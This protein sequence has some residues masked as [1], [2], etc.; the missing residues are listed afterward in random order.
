[1]FKKI[2]K[3]FSWENIKTL[4]KRIFRRENF[5][6]KKIGKFILYI[7]GIIIVFTAVLFIWY[8][9]DLPNPGKIKA[10]QPAQSTKIYDRNG[11]LLYDIHGEQRRTIIDS[12][13]IP[14]TLKQ[15][16][17]A[18]EDKVFYKHH[19]VDFTS[20]LRA[21][22]YDIINRGKSQGGSTITQQ[23]VKNALLTNEKTF[24][25][26]LKE[27]ILSIEI[28]FMYS[29]DQILTMYLNEI[30]YG[31]NAYGVEE[32]AK[33]YFGKSAKDL[34]LSESATLAALPQAPTYYSPY[35]NHPDKL[36]ARKN[37]ILDYMA[38]QNYITEDQAKAAKEEKVTYV[39]YKEN[40]TAP[41]FVMYVKEKLV[42]LYGE[43][44]V[45]E[46]GLK[47]TTTLDLDKQKIAEEAVNWGYERNASYNSPNA[48]LVSMDPKTGQIIAMVGSHDFY[49]KE[50]D[51]QVNVADTDQQPG[52]SF[53]PLVYATAFKEKYNPGYVLWDVTTDFGNYTPHNYN[54]NN[55]GP[56][57]IRTA[58]SNS[59]NIPAVKILSLVGIDKALETAHSMGITGLNDPDKYGLSLVLG[60]GEVKLVDLTTAY[61]VF[62]NKG[63][64]HE[65][66]PFLKIEDSG[67]KT[68]YEY[69]DTKGKKDV[70]DPQV[71]YEIS[72]ILSDNQAR[73]MT[74]GGLQAYLS[75]D[76]R[77][78]AVKTGTTEENRDA[79]TMGYTPSVVTGVWV[80]HND[81]TPMGKGADGSI[82]AAPIWHR[83]MEN[84]LANTNIEQF[85]QP[86][87]IKKVT[88]DKLSNKKPT[89]NSPETITDIFASWQIPT[90]FDDIHVKAKVC[91]ICNGEK[92]ANDQC[93]SDQTE[94]RT[95]TNLHSERPDNPKWE[96]PVLAW[97]RNNGM[98]VSSPPT[99]SCDISGQMPTISISSPSS[100]QTVS[101]NFTFSADAKSVFGVQKVE[102]FVDGVSIGEDNSSPYQ[103]SYNANYLSNGN[104]EL[105]ATVTDNKGLKVK[106]SITV[107]AAKDTTP[108]AAVTSVSLT[109]Q[110]QSVSFSWK[111]P[112]DS[113]FTK[114]RIYVST[115]S[116]VLGTKHPTEISGTAGGT[117]T[118]TISGLTTGTKY[119][120]SIR[121]VDSSD[122]ENQSSTQ[123][124]A[125]PL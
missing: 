65:T 95:F 99:E 68:L 40:I 56:V 94:E 18:I 106:N 120:F 108:P 102:F 46:G 53:K 123:Y 61:G 118:Y 14:D 104:H 112:S 80:G 116:G 28:E 19:G 85:E 15:A 86:E 96:Q 91:M 107:N 8:G 17:V 49:D 3:I 52:S 124:S 2:A 98:F 66:T 72:D 105:S 58:L 59:L 101:G 122:N 109:P 43:E 63:T 114:T 70:L 33:T 117:S 11:N 78:V 7:I 48:S 113:D 26:K 57:T 97:A 64:L 35:G 110:S 44:T 60:G 83:Y 100:N 81:N 20:I 16:T 71:A 34:N 39:P 36:E 51:G 92:L 29:K 69:S 73:S 75:F 111:N 54:G 27:L 103:T 31:S 42:D 89:D 62:A 115:T 37:T 87:G 82:V 23:Y 32:A 41:H 79:W 74:F 38:A 67:G 4:P 22:Y 12:K 21:V 6:P 25:R 76:D 5:T 13:D 90:E 9:R 10:L 125:T 24:D 77:A 119:Y 1:M 47:V 30:P 93:P 50:N 45:N 121:P 84:V 55:Y 88:V